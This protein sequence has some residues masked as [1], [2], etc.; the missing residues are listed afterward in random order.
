MDARTAGAWQST[1]AT[2]GALRALVDYSLASGELNGHYRYTVRRNGTRWAAGRV[3]P[4]NLPQSRTLVQP[5]GP[6]VQAGSTQHLT[7]SRQTTQGNGNLHYLVQ[8]QYYR[9]VDRIAPA[10]DGVAIS[11][12]YLTPDGRSGKLGSTIRVQLTVT[13]PQDLFYVALED[14][15]PAGAESVDSSLHTTSQL[16]QIQGQST[17]PP[18]MSDLA[19]YVTHTD[20]HDDRTVL[21]LS[22]L[23]AGIYHYTYL[24]HLDTAGRFHALPAR[25][26]ETYFPEVSAH[27]QGG[28]FTI[29]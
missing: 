23:P 14:P 15:L 12:R 8:L 19:W 17:I 28:Y 21:F 5:I 7:I 22:F 13:A 16:A 6:Q 3:T 9:P 24:I 18:A 25:I 11:R 29:R 1:A 26:G 2:A 10:G 27:G 4:T 20:L